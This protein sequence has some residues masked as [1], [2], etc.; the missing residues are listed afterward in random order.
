MAFWDTQEDFEHDLEMYSEIGD[1]ETIQEPPPP[2]IVEYNARIGANRNS[3]IYDTPALSEDNGI[4]ICAGRGRGRGSF[5]TY[6]PGV[7]ASNNISNDDE[8]DIRRRLKAVSFA[9]R[10]VFLV[11][12]KCKRK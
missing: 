6:R 9:N 8:D 7:A 4:V 1:I 12:F 10:T 2:S 5:K 3:S 11:L